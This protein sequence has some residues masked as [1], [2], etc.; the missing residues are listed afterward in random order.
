VVEGTVYVFYGWEDDPIYVGVTSRSHSRLHEHAVDKVW[1][2]DVERAKF[3]HWPTIGTA[4][5]RESQLI[6][7][8]EPERNR[9]RRIPFAEAWR[10]LDL[11][12]KW[13]YSS[14]NEEDQSNNPWLSEPK[15]PK[16]S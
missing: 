7:F 4:R 9:T 12:A 10:R 3:E 11:E 5:V 8:Y 15:Q 1:W 6:R 14:A 16:H 13:R 2:P